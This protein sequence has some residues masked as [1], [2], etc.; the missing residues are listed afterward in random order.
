MT[1]TVQFDSLVMR[2]AAIYEAHLNEHNIAIYVGG[3]VPLDDDFPVN[4]QLG[5]LRQA[6]ELMSNVVSKPNLE[7]IIINRLTIHGYSITQQSDESYWI[8]HHSGEGL[9]TTPMKFRK[10]IHDFYCKEF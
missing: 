3:Y 6:Y 5:L 2:L 10:L 1:E 8:Q 7:P 9:R 4:V